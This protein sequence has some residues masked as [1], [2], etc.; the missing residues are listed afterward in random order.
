MSCNRRQDEQGLR[1]G[2]IV[3]ALKTS[4]QE[5]REIFDR[6]IN[7]RDIAESLASFDSIQQAN[8]IRE[9]LE[10]R[11]FD[12]VGVREDGV[13]KGF[14]KKEDLT[15]GLMA[16]HVIEF[17][18]KNVLPER[19]PLLQVFKVLRQSQQVFVILKDQ[20][21]GI[22]TRGD[23]QKGP[24]R[25]W[26]FGLISLLEMNFLRMI[27]TCYPDAS[28]KK[29]LKAKRINKA[30]CILR[31]RKQRN[32]ATDLVDCLQFCDKV[33]IILKTGELMSA[34]GFSCKKEVDM[35]LGKLENLRNELAHSQDIITGSWPEICDLA[36]AAESIL[37]KCEEV[38]VTQTGTI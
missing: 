17:S 21:W 20:V 16:D 3:K 38:N 25:M 14:A 31:D 4:L 1:R 13:I 2:V 24:V 32:E 26:L 29:L 23:L 10:Q 12:V 27:R 35:L 18:E 33:D 28:W 6:S 22:V 5:M 8:Q 9:Y 19:A 36:D 7:V 15:S 34:L 37:P 11:D 30:E